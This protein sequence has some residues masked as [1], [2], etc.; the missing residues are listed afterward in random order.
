MSEDIDCIILKFLSEILYYRRLEVK[1]M[2]MLSRIWLY[3]IK[4]MFSLEG[5]TKRY[6]RPMW[7]QKLYF[8]I[9]FLIIHCHH[10]TN[11]GCELN[12]FLF[13][14]KFIKNC[15]SNSSSLIFNFSSSVR[16]CKNQK[17]D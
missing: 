17:L 15:K 9:M 7:V 4:H 8:C 3:S 5:Q 11:Q 12:R 6:C 1:H 13:E 14:F 10:H 2:P 16:C